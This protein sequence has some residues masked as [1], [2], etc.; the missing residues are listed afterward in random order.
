[1]KLIPDYLRGDIQLRIESVRR[2]LREDGI[3]AV[4]VASN[5][6]IYYTSARF[7]RGYVFIPVEGNPLWFVVRPV[8]FEPEADMVCIRKPEMIPGVLQERGIPAPAKLGLEYDSLS[9]S[10]VMRLKALFPEAECAD[11][12]M[13][14]KK[15]RM[16]KTPLEL[17]L[18]KEDGVHQA[19]A[20]RRVPH[21]YQEDMT[22]LQFQIEIERVLRLEGNLGFIRTSGNLMEI[23]MGSVIAGDNAD[24]PSPYDF[25]MGGAGVDPSL[26]GG[27]NGTTLKPGETVMVDMSGAFNGYQTDM[28]RV[29]SIGE[30]P[31]LALK[32]HE[33]SRRILRE[34]EKLALP[35]TEICELYRRAEEIAAGEG[36]SDYF[37]GH[38]QKAGFIGHGVGIELNEQPAITARNHTLIEESMTLALEPKFVIPH[39]GA[40]GPENTY[41]VRESGL[42]CITLFPEEIRNLL[43]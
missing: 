39:V 13:A 27:A 38:T 12:S 8:G 9:Y 32:A 14:L 4:I 22:D 2:H 33:C 20:Y 31:E 30:L 6:N 10:D 37:M 40:V 28:T 1:M 43:R 16:I 26:P 15:A 3:D 42:E 18:M 35:G 36:L 7:F 29:W 23:N 17:Q 24:V 19:E 41:V 5:A 25:T 11:A 34:L 21:C